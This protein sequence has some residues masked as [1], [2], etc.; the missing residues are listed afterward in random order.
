MIRP[1]CILFSLCTFLQL[2]AQTTVELTESLSLEDGS[3][4][5]E[6]TMTSNSGLKATVLNYGATLTGMHTP[7]RDGEI[8]NI[9]LY[10]EDP[11]AY[12]GRH[13]L[14]G[15]VVGRFANRIDTG[16]FTIDGTRYELETFNPK[17][18]VHIHGG[19]TGFQKQF[20]EAEVLEDGVRFSLTSEH[21]HEGFPGKLEASVTYRLTNDDE[22]VMH[23]EATTDRPTHVNLTN[24]AYWNL[25]G[26][27]S[28]SILD[29][30]L[31]IKADSILA[32]DSRKIP[33][34]ELLPVEGSPFDFR[35]PSKV[36][37]R[38]DAVDGGGYDHC[39]A[40]DQNA[41]SSPKS[42]AVVE[43]T[44]SGRVMEVLTTAPGLQLYTANYLNPNLGAE[45]K[46]YGPHHAICLECQHFPDTPNKPGFP[47]TL[48]RP[49][50]TYRQTTIHR[51]SV[52]N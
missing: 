41:N 21:G 39:F 14:L 42:V 8:E 4:L 40:F 33:T 34:G 31:Q 22:L 30:L 37:A 35:L 15:S 24:H 25:G 16:G 43:D 45:G 12:M 2:D 6:F 44:T 20:W 46:S 38:I 49:G 32:I 36:G 3:E 48:L 51:F 19:K 1:L 10:L 5:K 13:P 7:N 28:G 29:H 26:A 11:K 47:S 52:R 18:K 27:T 17:T 9:T 50:E 23:Y